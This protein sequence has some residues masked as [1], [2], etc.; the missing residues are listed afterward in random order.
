[1]LYFI[2]LNLNYVSLNIFLYLKYILSIFE[3]I[4][5]FNNNNYNNIIY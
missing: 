5:Q 1:M 2:T 4:K 3:F